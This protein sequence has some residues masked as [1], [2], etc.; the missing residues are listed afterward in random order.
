MPLHVMKP[1]PSPGQFWAAAVH[2]LRTRRPVLEAGGGSLGVAA[3]VAAAAILLGE[4]QRR[5]EKEQPRSWYERLVSHPLVAWLIENSCVVGSTWLGCMVVPA[6]RRGSL[7]SILR[8]IILGSTLQVWAI[9]AMQKIVTDGLYSHIPTFTSP[10]RP[11]PGLLQYVK[12]FC[13]CNVPVDFVNSLMLGSSIAAYSAKKF[14]SSFISRSFSPS[15][16]LR[17]LAIGRF[18][19]DIGFWAGHR[20]LHHPKLYFLHRRH[21]GHHRPALITNFHFAPLDLWVEGVMPM[22]IT[23]LVLDLLRVGTTRFEA[24]LIVGYL[25][26]HETGSHCG[27]PLPTVTFFPPL[28]PLYQL[29]LGPVD[30]DNIRHHDV[31]HARLNGNYGITIWPDIVMGTRLRDHTAPRETHRAEAAEILRFFSRTKQ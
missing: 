19:V 25:L 31:H 20:L 26:W 11:K 22:V 27:K 17:A 13:T 12:E 15:K 21:H 9:M 28:A 14:Q 30:R 18:C 2:A 10:G 24:N 4:K 16:F 3:L 23:L 7:A 5:K 1:Q 6:P 8:H 29:L